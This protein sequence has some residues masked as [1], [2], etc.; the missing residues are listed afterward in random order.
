MELAA[1][2]LSFSNTAGTGTK[3]NTNPPRRQTPLQDGSFSQSLIGSPKTYDIATAHATTLLS[4]EPAEIIYIWH[5][6]ANTAA[7]T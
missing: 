4:R 2:L 3:D 7:V 5:L 1:I 6:S